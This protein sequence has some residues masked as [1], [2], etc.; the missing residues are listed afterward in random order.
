VSWFDTLASRYSGWSKEYILEEL[1]LPVAMQLR[2][3]ALREAG[4]WTVIP[5]PPAEEQWEQKQAAWR[6]AL[7]G[8]E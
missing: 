5:A 7:E 8:S 1:P 6:Q 3:R 2:H 4:F